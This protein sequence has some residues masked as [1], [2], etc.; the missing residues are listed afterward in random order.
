MSTRPPRF[1]GPDFSRLWVGDFVSNTGTAMVTFAVPVIGVTELGLSAQ[2]ISWVAAAS[3]SAPLFFSLSAGALAD[4]LRRSF[5]LHVCN[6]ARFVIF[7]LLCV[8]F[9]VGS[10][11]WVS[12]A[13]GLFAVGV[14]NLLY[15]SSMAA[16]VPSVVSKGDLVKANSW[17]E[18]GLSVSETGGPVFSG[19]ILN[20]FGALAILVLNAVSYLF[21]SLMLLGLPLDRRGSKDKP[22]RFSI[23]GHL[24]EV[25]LGFRLIW[26]Q[27]PQRVAL[28]AAT[29]YNFFDSW[30][31]AIFSVFALTVLGLSPFTFGLV[32][33]VATVTGIV[34]SG[35]AVKLTDRYGFG[36][37]LVTSFSMIAMAGIA[38]AFSV[39]LE[40]LSAAVLVAA[41]FAIFE[42]CIVVN[43]IIG[44]T[45]R[46][47]LFPEEHISK[48]AGTAR[49]LSWGVD[50]LGAL[51]GGACAAAL[52]L[53]TSVVIA[54]CGFSLAAL[55]CLCSRELRS[56][57]PVLA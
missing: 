13:V 12:L 38:L 11:G 32:F 42:F 17:I 18:G 2:Q 14:L 15:E 46:Q 1:R 8:L 28:F 39:L 45:M 36:T 29:L 33:A 41:V 19:F 10:L 23:K 40:G 6:I 21:S 43:M 48:V 16:A 56:F 31:F 34:G 50:P 24:S 35:V 3:L 57:R 22:E 9:L 55:V 37:L 30:L 7:A 49:F 5:L 52:G 27:V 53:E 54:C 51:V 4:R 26:G 47:T 20:T 44:R 25:W